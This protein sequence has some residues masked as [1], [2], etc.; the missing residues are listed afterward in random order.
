MNYGKRCSNPK[1]GERDL[2]AEYRGHGLGVL[3]AACYVDAR[4][5]STRR[6]AVPERVQQDRYAQLAARYGL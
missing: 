4:T 2:T 5:S 3:C 1:H 6:V